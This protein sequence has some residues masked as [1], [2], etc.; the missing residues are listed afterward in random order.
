[1]ME[2]TRVPSISVSAFVSGWGGFFPAGEPKNPDFDLKTLE[3]LLF[4]SPP[5]APPKN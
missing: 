1:M 3:T 4:F 5:Q 2:K